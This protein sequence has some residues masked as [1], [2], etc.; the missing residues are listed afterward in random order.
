MWIY[1]LKKEGGGVEVDKIR[2]KISKLKRQQMEEDRR[3][4]TES[5]AKEEE[6]RDI[7]LNGFCNLHIVEARER[8]EREQREKEQKLAREL[9]EPLKEPWRKISSKFEDP[10]TREFKEE[11][12]QKINAIKPA[13]G[14]KYFN[15]LLLGQ[16]ASGKSSFFNTCLTA[17]INEDRLVTSSLIYQS[18]SRSVTTALE[19]IPMKTKEGKILPLRLFDCRGLNVEYGVPT[20][21]I[22]AIVEGRVKSGYKINPVAPIDEDDP[23]Y[24]KDPETKDRMHCVV[25]V[26][27]AENPAEQLTDHKTEEQLRYVRENLARQHL[28]QMVLFNKVDRL[29][30]SNTHNLR[31]IFRSQDVK[32]TCTK[33]AEYMQI[34]LTHVFPMANYHEENLPTLEKDILALFYLLTMMQ[35]ANDFILRLTKDDVPDDFYD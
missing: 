35:R 27:N 29:R 24:R 32:D 14:I 16:A 31:D 9:E 6:I 1:S 8:Q 17:I 15:I 5:K 22:R 7:G 20:E 2:R 28:P 3:K 10:W 23:Y 33:A 11:L 19:A 18:S 34:P 25:Y 30:I 26:A 12:L 13:G 21:D 4:Q